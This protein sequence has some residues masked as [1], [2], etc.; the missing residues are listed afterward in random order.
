MIRRLLPIS[1][2]LLLLSL[3]AIP[4]G[5]QE[6]PPVTPQDT[7]LPVGDTIPDE[8]PLPRGAFIRGMLVPGWGHFS[9]GE[10]RRG[11]IYGS[12]QGASWFMLVKTMGRL[13]DARDDARGLTVLG[14]DSVNQA[15]AADTALAN[16]LSDP[17]AYEQAVLTYPGLAGSRALVTSRERHRQDWIVYT[18][19]TTFAGAV[20]A[21]VTAHLKDFPGEIMT[22]RS[23]DGG[24]NVGL[25][26]P[27]GG[28]R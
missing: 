15:M 25:R 11:T 19:V 5:A 2:A 1:A 23:R 17:E 22:G 4:T 13:E 24:T 12:L 28:R 9:V 14:R 21:Y 7:L 8:G 16:R 27:V 6:V 3:A 20:D 26:V 18:L 10:P